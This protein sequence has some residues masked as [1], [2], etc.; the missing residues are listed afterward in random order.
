MLYNKIDGEIGMTVLV[1]GGA[2]Y[3][4]SHT[5]YT[6]IENR[7]D[8]VVIDNLTTGHL[9]AVHPKA[10]FY[11]GDI[12]NKVFLDSI[13]EKE[14]ID[15]V[16]HF[17]AY[18]VV[19]ESMENPLKYYDNNVCKTKILLESM[20][21]HEINKIV[22][23]STASVYGEPE[24]IPILESDK[25]IPTNT[26]GETKLSIEKMLKWVN[27]ANELKYVSLRYFNAAGAHISGNIGEDHSPETHLIP[28]ILKT[29]D[30]QKEYISIFGDDYDT[31]D[32]TC[33][34]DYVHVSDLSDAHISAVNYLLNGG[35]SSIFNLGSGFGY[36]VKEIL[37]VARKIT[38]KTINVKISERRLGDSAKLLASN[39]KAKEMLGWNP[40]YN[41][42]EDI[43][44]TAWNWH[45]NHKKGYEK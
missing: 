17:A 6:L 1:L 40:K 33:I 36:S 7:I 5:V 12:G 38:K 19:G 20:I 13:F 21:E 26:Y 43:I 18:S 2:G 10:R 34:R 28:L 44:S 24:N 14:K 37:D 31:K 45:K 3:I 39:K 9:E 32:G 8:T 11:K 42:I 23:S 22:F 4:G 35:E 29:A 30:G 41:N 25:T 15:I 16:I 27:K